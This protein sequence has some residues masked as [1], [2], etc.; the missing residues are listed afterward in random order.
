MNF[1]NTTTFS[2]ALFLSSLIVDFDK[3]IMASYIE[4]ITRDTQ[5]PL[6]AFM[7]MIIRAGCILL[8]LVSS[9]IY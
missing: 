5:G 2:I 8:C 7:M 4:V 3:L 9:S 6:S 1:D